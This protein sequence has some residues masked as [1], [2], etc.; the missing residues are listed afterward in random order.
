M[1]QGRE[2]YVPGGYVL[3][4]AWINKDGSIILHYR[5]KKDERYTRVVNQQQKGYRHALRLYRKHWGEAT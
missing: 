4:I 2:G 1:S 3:H 5:N